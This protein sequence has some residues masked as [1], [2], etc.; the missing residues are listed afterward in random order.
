[1]L[2][3]WN[4]V[5]LQVDVYIGL[6]IVYLLP[7]LKVRLRKVKYLIYNNNRLYCIVYQDILSIYNHCIIQIIQDGMLQTSNKMYLIYI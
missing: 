3:I 4:F 7:V 6:Q 2:L 5:S 1:M